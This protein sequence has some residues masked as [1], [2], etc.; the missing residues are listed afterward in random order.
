[1]NQY[2]P[3]IMIALVRQREFSQIAEHERH[4]HAAKKDQAKRQGVVIRIIDGIR[5]RLF[6][7]VTNEGNTCMQD[8][9]VTTSASR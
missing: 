5:C 2:D 8:R 3:L 9:A 7:K 4:I 1:M 6:V